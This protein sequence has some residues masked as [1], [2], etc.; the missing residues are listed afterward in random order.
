MASLGTLVLER[1]LVTLTGV[2]G[3]GKTRLAIQVAAEVAAE[4]S[5]GAFLCELAGVADP[6][7]VWD[8]LA[9]TLGVQRNPSRSVETSVLDFL[10]AKR[11]LLI[12]DNCEHL[13]GAVAR[14]VDA[15]ARGCPAVALLA[16]SR[17]GLALPGEQLIAVPA[18]GVPADD[19][20]PTSST[21]ADAVELFCDRA[22][23]ADSDLRPH[24][25]E[26]RRGG[27]VVPPARRHSTGDRAGGHARV[28]SLTPQDLVD[29]LDQRFRLLTRGSRAAL[30]RHQTLRNTID[31]SYN[32]LDATEQ[33]ALNRLS[34]FA[35]SWDLS[36]AEAIISPDDSI[37]ALD[38]LSHLVD[39]SL[40]I[41]NDTAGHA[42]YRLLETIRQYAQE[43]LEASGDTT[44][45]R[46]LHAEHYVALAETAGP[47]LR[48]HEQ[49]DWVEP[50]VR[51]AE[52]FR[53]ALDW[54]VETASADHALR[55][56]APLMVTGIPVGWIATDWADIARRVPGAA[57]HQLFP[58]VVAFAAMAATMR[59]D[60]DEAESLVEEAQQAQRTLGT[61]HLWVDAAAGTLAF[62]R[63]D[64][65]EATRH[66]Q[67]WADAASE[68]A[69]PYEI[70]HALILL[71]TSL[72]NDPD[73]A[74]VIADEAVRVARDAGI[75]SAFCTPCWSG[76]TFRVTTRSACSRCSTRRPKSARDSVTGKALRASWHS[77]AS[78]RAEP[79]TGERHSS[80]SSTRP[81]STA[82]GLHGRRISGFV[83]GNR[84]R[85]RATRMPRDRRCP[86]GIRRHRIRSGPRRLRPRAP[87]RDRG[88]ARGGTEPNPDR[89]LG[90][91]RKNPRPR[92]SRR[93]PRTRRP[94]ELS[95]RRERA[96]SPYFHAAGSHPVPCRIRPIQPTSSPPVAS[97]PACV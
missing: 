81:L 68:T 31:W 62:F 83:L 54:A 10:A 44:L 45:V 5:H 24:R 50:L 4:F 12:L 20:V 35:G 82:R 1:R 88:N 39:K 40:V 66:A 43:R 64:F 14:V 6:D 53:A 95:V 18:L 72:Q 71:A 85:V 51:E 8:A 61:H 67:A 11:M 32:L 49:L 36:A 29:R 89:G 65:A 79:A 91:T 55:L 16:T 38:L 80:R 60:L 2:G 33:T 90:G 76:R 56:V 28:R 69:D 84:P 86:H 70:S 96:P 37:G 22:H 30:E 75:A 26:R 25:K 97:A 74:V 47:H 17:E 46:R 42:R 9:T 7:A 52:N 94:A 21:D 93:V 23:D 15:I 77:G 3:V 92:G 87:D 48:G 19:G 59:N 13:L 34:V 27:T 58:L 63:A 73:R 57:L 41:V 78:S